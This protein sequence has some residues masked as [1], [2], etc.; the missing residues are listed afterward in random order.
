M[1]ELLD[2]AVEH[3][4][5]EKDDRVILFNRMARVRNGIIELRDKADRIDERLV[6][7]IERCGM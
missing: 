7:N 1:L 6:Q 3:I 4:D 5:F 2:I